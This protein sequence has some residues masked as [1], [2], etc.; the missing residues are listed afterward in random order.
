MDNSINILLDGG[1]ERK[2]E[3]EEE[4]AAEK[5]GKRERSECMCV[6]W[7]KLKSLELSSMSPEGSSCGSCSLCV[8]TGSES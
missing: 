8:I 1:R 5:E 4:G 6:C 3:G 7:E 2:G